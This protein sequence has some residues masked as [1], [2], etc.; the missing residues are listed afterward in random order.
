MEEMRGQG[1]RAQVLVG[2]AVLVIAILNYIFYIFTSS[3]KRWVRFNIYLYKL[4]QYFPGKGSTGFI[5]YAFFGPLLV[6]AVPPLAPQSV[7]EWVNTP[8]MIAIALGVTTFIL[9]RDKLE[10]IQEEALKEEAEEK[11]REMEFAGIY[12]WI[13]RLW[14]IRRIARWTYKEGWWYSGFLAGILLV[15][16]F[17]RFWNLGELGIWSD[18]GTVYISSKNILLS[19]VPYLETGLLYARDYPHL[20][21]T[22]ASLAIFGKSEFALRF[23]SAVFGTL[24][25]PI[26]YILTKNVIGNKQIALLAS[27]IIATHPWLLEYSRV[28]RSYI[29]MIFLLYLSVLYFYKAC[30]AGTNKRQN[31]VIF[32]LSGFFT[33][34]THQLGQI[35]VFLIPLVPLRFKFRKENLNFLLSF[36]LIV[37]GIIIYRQLSIIGYRVYTDS[38]I[39][40][41]EGEIPSLWERIP[42]GVPVTSNLGI[43]MDVTPS[44]TILA[45]SSVVFLLLVS[46][47]IKERRIRYSF[48]PLVFLIFIATILFSKNP[49]NENKI[50]LFIFPMIIMLAAIIIMYI[51]SIYKTRSIAFEKGLP[52]LILA[53]IAFYA[54]SSYSTVVDRDYGDPIN[55][56]YSSFEGF[57][58]YQDHK[59]TIQ[60]VNEHYRD[61]DLIIIY[62]VPQYWVF[63]GNR[64]PDYRVW[65]GTTYTINGKNI[66]T[67]TTELKKLDELKAIIE[68]NERVWIVTSYSILSYKTP[69]IF[70]ISRSLINYL[71]DFKDDIV[72]ISK[73]T[74]ARV[75]LVEN[76]SSNTSGR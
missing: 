63:Y 27:G 57:I 41:F 58:F 13:N 19:G 46:L 56:N 50:I 62:Q 35:I 37:L 22:A 75:Y 34:L 69:R 29:M 18:E 64:L 61:G 38:Y 26:I 23:P 44:L 4:Y 21:V 16:I 33:T 51:K 53:L 66:F 36:L 59:T 8:L 65:T 28:S 40:T 3:K 72:Y 5:S 12:P 68:N 25:I 1:M 70:H 14:L 49:V 17:L 52:V 43:F 60:Y 47:T 15:G 32:G 9:I 20:Y 31:L 45:A 54:F 6:M 73:D 42:F 74:S 30:Y 2:L 39:E 48:L 76:G 11:R 7:S 71:D 55:P 10:G 24:L 67:G